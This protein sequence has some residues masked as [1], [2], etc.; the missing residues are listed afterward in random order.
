MCLRK[1]A[2]N[3]QL[4][5]QAFGP[6]AK[7]PAAPFGMAG[8]VACG[9]YVSILQGISDFIFRLAD[10]FL[11]AAFDLVCGSVGAKLVVARR[12]A[13]L[14]LHLAAQFLR[15]ALYFVIVLLL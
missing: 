14:V 7:K 4:S 1:H 6:H 3:A 10:A 11:K 5:S 12:L 2:A 13:D 9:P 8:L 15:R